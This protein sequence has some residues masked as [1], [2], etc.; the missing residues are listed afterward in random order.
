MTG[1]STKPDPFSLAEMTRRG[2]RIEWCEGW[3]YKH[4]WVFERDH[5]DG[6]AGRDTP[7]EG[8]GWERNT[9]IGNAGEPAGFRT[10]D[11]ASGVMWVSYWR[12][13]A[14]KP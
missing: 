8:D 2:H 11:G 6:W 4:T 5:P 14:V 9:E 13:P 10:V 1:P 7:P 12:R 3:E